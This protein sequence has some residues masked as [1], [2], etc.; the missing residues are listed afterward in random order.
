[1][2]DT[3]TAPAAAGFPETDPGQ[4]VTNVTL[5]RVTL[6]DLGDTLP[7][8]RKRYRFHKPNLGTLKRLGQLQGDNELNKKPGLF[9]VTYLAA[10]LA[11][12]G[13]EDFGGVERDAARAQKVAQLPAGDV[14]TLLVAWTHAQHVK[15]G[16]AFPGAG[17]GACGAEWKAVRV[18]LGGLEVLSIPADHEGPAGARVGL[19]EGFTVHGREARAVLIQAPTWGESLGSLSREAWRNPSA[20]RAATIQG[21]IRACDAFPKL[22]RLGA[23]SLDEF[24]PADL[25]LLDEALGEITAS[26]S[27]EIGI[28]CPDCG[29]DNRTAMDW[30]NLG[31]SGGPAGL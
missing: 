13:G 6:A 21:A 29:A 27:L 7:A 14:L 18:N 19:W 3:T 4:I 16:V 11:E 17:C 23:E 10:A 5:E 24:M 15:N 20:I 1:M 22:G 2:N 28:Q 30:K 31:F 26:V 8:S 9:V 25:E 12:L